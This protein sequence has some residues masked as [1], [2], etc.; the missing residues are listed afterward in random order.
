MMPLNGSSFLRS[1]LEANKTLTKTIVI[2]SSVS[3]D[4]LN[5]FIA[6]KYGESSVNRNTPHTW[7][8]YLNISGEYHPVDIQMVVTSLDT[9][10]EIS[11]TKQ[12]LESHF[13]T[14]EAYAYGTRYYYSLLNKYPEN[15]QL[16][17]G[18][19]NPV[20]IDKAILAKD[21]SILTYPEHL[22]EPQEQTL[23]NDLEGFIQRHMS[24]WNNKALGVVDSLYNVGYHALMYLAIYPKLLNLRL[25]RCKTSE[26]HSF[27]IR[28][29]LASI[30]GLDKYLPYMT[31][32]Q[33]LYF[34]RNIV[35]LKKNAGKT[36]TLTELIDHI[37]TE[38][39]I[40]ISEYSV[41]HLNTFDE[42]Y[43]PNI[44]LRRKPLNS[45]YNVAEK[46]YVTSEEL[47]SKEDK[48][49]YGN[50]RYHSYRARLDDYVFKN[51]NSSVIQTKDLESNMVDYTD[52]VPDTLE[53]VLF[54]QWIDLAT[55]GYY[56]SVVSFKDPKSNETISLNA[57][58]CVIYYVYVMCK[59]SGLTLD[60]VPVFFI[61]K[62]RKLVKPTVAE[63]LSVTDSK[64]LSLVPLAYNLHAEQPTTINCTSTKMF[65][66]RAYKIYTE[67]KRHWILLA[68][69]HDV[70]ERG[71][72]EGM[73]YKLYNDKCIRLLPEGTLMEPWLIS[74][75]LPLYDYSVPQAMELL[76]NI[77]SSATGIDTDETKLLKNIQ[78]YMLSLLTD[79]S[80]YSIQ[81]IREIND[82]K[83]IPLNWAAI[84]AGNS[85][86]SGKH[87]EYLPMHVRVQ[88]FTSRINQS[89]NFDS[90]YTDFTIDGI[91]GKH[92]L[93]LNVSLS[94]VFSMIEKRKVILPLSLFYCD[95]DYPE[96]NIAVS[97]KSAAIG[98]EYY[99]LLPTETKQSL[100]S[101]YN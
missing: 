33:A 20:D 97:S 72:L 39:R 52:A 48:L 31:L 47:Y 98:Q 75:N 59:L 100:K 54:R 23:I 94:T 51:S 62:A 57:K 29:Y 93:S 14:K 11:F 12:S 70:Y 35:Y 38:R 46:D 1:Y 25:A 2:K 44:T 49:V 90:T 42:N 61:E 85:K 22:V 19:L 87:Y 77:F 63:M 69:T 43:Y 71:D 3:A 76:I 15:E 92:S 56:N 55:S 96:Y 91:K 89:Y 82:S 73:I 30:G 74:N 99:D 32:K 10:E 18:I 81:I 40:P 88:S 8:Y 37:L 41:R 64:F 53:A 95:V 66:D 5:D 13:A 28:E 58:D 80:S 21:G 50:D 4:V 60:E 45:Q 84:R 68:N 7:K 24:R 6:L 101:I 83:V 9:L 78:K 67:A 17:L 65:Y 79:L 36:E 27:H 26:A 16:I 86:I 34:Y